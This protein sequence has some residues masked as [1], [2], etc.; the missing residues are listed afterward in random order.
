MLTKMLSP[1]KVLL[2]NG[3]AEI[4]FGLHKRPVQTQAKLSAKWGAPLR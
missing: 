4:T 3:S 1:P 2:Q